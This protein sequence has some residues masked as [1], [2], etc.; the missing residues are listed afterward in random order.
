LDAAESK[1]KHLRVAG[2]K[3]FALL[4]IPLHRGL[5]HRGLL[6]SLWGLGLITAASLTLIPWLGWPISIALPLGYA[7]HLATDAATRS[8]IPWLY[9]NKRRYH[10][11]PQGYRF[12]TGSYAEQ[13]L[14][15]PLALIASLLLL[16]VVVV[17][18]SNR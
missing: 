4:S 18:I 5:G 17:L 13:M 8:G 7:S 16:R 6:H 2:I 14:C 1:L 3:P 11:L 10:L 9:L 15:P 12:V